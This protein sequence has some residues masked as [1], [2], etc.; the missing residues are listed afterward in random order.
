[1]FHTGRQLAICL[2]LVGC[3]VPK[4]KK[5]SESNDPKSPDPVHLERSVQSGEIEITAR[6]DANETSWVAHAKESELKLYSDSNIAGSLKTVDG[7]F[8]NDGEK[9]GTFVADTAIADRSD[10]KLVLDKGIKVLSTDR[11]MTLEAHRVEWMADRKLLQCIG[12]VI[13][14]GETGTYG[15][16]NLLW[17]SPSL[18]MVGTPDRF[19]KDIEMKKYLASLALP[20]AVAAQIH[21]QTPDQ[22]IVVSGMSSWKVK[23][24]ADGKVHIEGSGRPIKIEAPESNWSLTSQNL[25]GDLERGSQDWFVKSGKFTGDV[26]FNLGDDAMGFYGNSLTWTGSENS[27]AVDLTGGARAHMKTVG[28][29]RTLTGGTVHAVI[30]MAGVQT[31]M[32]TG[33]VSGH[34]HIESNEGR[35]ITT[36]DGERF[37]FSSAK[38]VS[39]YEAKSHWTGSIV[40]RS[41][42]S[43][44]TLNADSGT[45]TTKQRIGRNEDGLLGFDL[46]GHV[47]IVIT[48]RVQNGVPISVNG[49]A[50][51][52]NYVAATRKLTLRGNVSI[53]GNTDTLSGG[54]T[55]S[56]AILTFD[57][58]GNLVEFEAKGDPGVSRIKGGR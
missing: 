33:F 45:V 52:M 48:S 41:N 19:S 50:D 9:A 4:P 55:A 23:Q 46:A 29:D 13:V 6:N 37:E 28:G 3:G 32:T 58:G 24:I 16:S 40:D 12:N 15:P 2:L 36:L 42:E 18:Q 22:S 17:A 10:Q 39:T 27:G 47:T 54:T 51:S 7:A 11:K 21:Y 20:A 53:K 14:S 30:S 44:T 34:A 49:S 5:V 31:E 56:E 8:Y 25:E 26:K 57:E 1:M 43:K 38:G 35:R